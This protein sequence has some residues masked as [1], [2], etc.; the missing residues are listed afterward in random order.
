[1][2]TREYTE[3]ISQ[4][5]APDGLRDRI[6]LKTRKAAP[7]A[8]ESTGSLESNDLVR[9]K[10]ITHKDG[11]LA[12]NK[13]IKPRLIAVL[14][15][16][17]TF[18]FCV[19][20]AYYYGAGEA[21][22]SYFEKAGQLRLNQNEVKILDEAAKVLVSEDSCEGYTIKTKGLFSDG[23]F[24]YVLL[25]IS[26]DD[27]KPMTG[28][29][30]FTSYLRIKDEANDDPILRFIIPEQLYASENGNAEFML[31]FE[32]GNFY[33]MPEDFDLTGKDVILEILGLTEYD[34]DGYKEVIAPGYSWQ[35]NFNFSYTTACKLF[36]FVDKKAATEHM[37]YDIRYLRISPVSLK[38]G[39]IAT[40]KGDYYS[41]VMDVEIVSKDGTVMDEFLDTAGASAA[42]DMPDA[43]FI[44]Y[45][46]FR[47]PLDVNAIK[48]IRVNGQEINLIN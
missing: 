18:I 45:Y 31:R 3:R 37:D 48:S 5:K 22:R 24:A 14:A 9:F 47:R 42:A 1:M 23:D 34:A 27:G 40:V 39:A 13:K 19:G 2:D 16:V 8:S 29:Y 43:N 15:A 38:V 36:T 12:G 11:E 17:I 6:I 28:D 20:A 7:E 10:N 26:R 46:I 30:M 41:P 4:I 21:L 25:E 32:P 33:R 44:T 35:L